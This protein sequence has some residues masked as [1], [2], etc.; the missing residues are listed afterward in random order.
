MENFKIVNET[1]IEEREAEIVEN[2][3]CDTCGHKSTSAR[4]LKV[5]INLHANKL[6]SCQYCQKV[7][8]KFTYVQKHILNVHNQSIYSCEVCDKK[9][10]IKANLNNH[11]KPVH[12]NLLKSCS[13]C[14]KSIGETNIK[15]TKNCRAKFTNV[16][17]KHYIS[18]GNSEIPCQ[19]SCVKCQKF[20]DNQ[21]SLQSHIQNIHEQKQIKCEKCNKVF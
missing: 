1:I 7:F 14:Q 12:E 15:G 6:V 20:Y 21:K 18:N 11:Q 9:F 10:T 8:N 4:K 19:Y 16:V 2:F 13:I 17:Q 5:H 3:V